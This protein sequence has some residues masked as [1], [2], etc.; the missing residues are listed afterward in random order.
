M[1]FGSKNRL[2]KISSGEIK[3]K[4]CQA[5]LQTVSSYTYLGLT[6][7][8]YLNY[9]SHVNKTIGSVTNKLNQFRRMRQ[10]LTVKAALM[11]YKGMLLPILE[12]GDVFLTGASATNRKRLQI[13]QNKGLRCA[14]NRDIYTSTE[15]LHTEASLLKLKFRREQHILNFMYD[16]AQDTANRKPKSK[17]TV[18][19][20]SSD[21]IL[22]KIK[23]P[24]T[25]KKSLT[26]K[27]PKKWNN[28]S[29]NYHKESSKARYKHIVS[30]WV[31]LRAI[32]S[33]CSTSMWDNT[34]PL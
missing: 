21:K 25:E 20:R 9:N 22:L 12:Y 33:D 19:T 5:T 28:L 4:L 29:A 31:A 11:V 27:G 30:D 24:R 3:L 10:F 7:D 8:S 13:L 34:Q 23:R 1:V 14:L 6:L 15:D 32:Q 16:V 26:Y 2:A 17:L 18:I